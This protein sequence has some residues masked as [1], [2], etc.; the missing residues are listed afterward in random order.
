MQG[1]NICKLGSVSKWETTVAYE[2]EE[3]ATD[4]RGPRTH[5]VIEPTSKLDLLGS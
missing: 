5:A 1:T 3:T 2:P 4:V